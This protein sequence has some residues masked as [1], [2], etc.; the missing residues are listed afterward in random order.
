MDEKHPISSPGCLPSPSPNTTSQ[1]PPAR[2]PLS[3]WLTLTALV[4]MM[5]IGLGLDYDSECLND[6]DADDFQV[7]LEHDVVAQGRLVPLE[8]HIMSKCPDAEVFGLSTAS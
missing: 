6:W 7:D 5:W 8:A 3:F 4:A 1:R 2:R